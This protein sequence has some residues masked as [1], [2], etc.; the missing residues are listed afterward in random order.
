MVLVLAASQEFGA[1]VPPL[2]VVRSSKGRSNQVRNRAIRRVGPAEAVGGMSEGVGVTHTPNG[3]PIAAALD[4]ASG[5]QKVLRRRDHRH[6]AM[7][8][9]HVADPL[10]EGWEGG[11]GL[12]LA[13]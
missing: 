2:P 12:A 6:R 3:P 1:I 10:M 9:A 8:A 4:T 7:E 13:F 11:Q 5:A